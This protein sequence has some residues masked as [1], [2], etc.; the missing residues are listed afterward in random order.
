M[1]PDSTARKGI[2]DYGETCD[3]DALNSLLRGEV[4]AVESYDQV[5]LKFEGRAQSATL[6]RMRGDHDEAAAVLRERVRHFGGEP[7]QRS[8]IWGAFTAAVTGTAKILGPV[9][10]LGTL[11]EGEEVGIGRYESALTHPDID[12]DCKDLIRYR[13]LPR[14]QNH[15]TELLRMMNALDRK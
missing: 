9:T 2:D 11:K 8:G 15:V 10:A 14:C 13:L 4:S 1:Y 12:P 5:L 3:I 7:A 6:H